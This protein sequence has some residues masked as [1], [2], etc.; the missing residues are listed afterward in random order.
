VA[1]QIRSPLPIVVLGG[2]DAR[3]GA[4]P[5]GVHDKHALAGYK[6]VAVR[7]GGRAMID[8]VI[9]R[10]E[11][12]GLFA[13]IYIAGPQ[14][15]YAHHRRSA[16][17]IDVT[18]SIDETIR[19]GVEGASRGHPGVPLALAT[20]DVLPDVETLARLMA[21]YRN[22]APCDAFLPMIRAPEDAA[23]GVSGYKP[24]YQV[25][26]ED[27]GGAVRVLPCH[28]AVLDVEALR[29]DFIYRFVGLIYRTRNR[30]IA[31]R[32]RVMLPGIILELLYQDLR[33]LL[34]LRLP[35]LTWTVLHSGLSAVRALKA[36]TITRAQLE[37]AFRR[38]FVTARHRSRYPERRVLMPVMEGLSLALDIDTEEEAAA[39]GG[40]L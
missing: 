28:L 17:V 3:A 37:D 32:R 8:C 38:V 14:S 13:P 27:G 11:Q 2:R 19:R 36:G 1:V 26:P 25:V 24:T 7:I 40:E 31:Y 4:M 34:G 39:M 9:E 35:N 33:H 5:A 16:T 23:L 6:G 30:P 21:H 12:S 18:G 29:M 22:S 20:C 15:V 10:L